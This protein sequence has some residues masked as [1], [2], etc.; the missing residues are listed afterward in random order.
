[1]Y[2]YTSRGTQR[3]DIHRTN[4]LTMAAQ[5]QRT[6]TVL[7]RT[8]LSHRHNKDRTWSYLTESGGWGGWEASYLLVTLP[9]LPADAAVA[10]CRHREL[11][12]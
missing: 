4:E 7:I 1:M 12:N 2:I 5:E 9:L 3:L 11:C 8:T 6:T 10:G